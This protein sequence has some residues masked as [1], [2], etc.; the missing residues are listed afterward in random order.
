MSDSLLLSADA[1]APTGLLLAMIWLEVGLALFGCLILVRRVRTAPARF[2]GLAPSGLTASPL[3]FSEFFLGAA[4][5][6]G[7]ACIVQVAAAQV[8]NHWFPKAPDSPLGVH[9]IIVGAGFQLGLLAGLGYAW[10]WHLRPERRL[11]NE[12]KTSAPI[13]TPRSDEATCIMSGEVLPKREMFEFDG[14][15]VSAARKETYLRCLREGIA[16]PVLGDPAPPSLATL[17]ATQAAI[18]Q[19]ADGEV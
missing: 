1:S 9:D 3:R 4:C 13:R 16:L 8:A 11:Q 17:V 12:P 18:A 5:A 2:L 6:I 14:Q 15:W 10:Q 19:D 7:G